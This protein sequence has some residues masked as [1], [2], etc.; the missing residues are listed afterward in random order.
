MKDIFIL[1][2][3]ADYNWCVEN[4]VLNHPRIIGIYTTKLGAEAALK[5]IT[6]TIPHHPDIKY[7]IASYPLDTI[8]WTNTYNV[9]IA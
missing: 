4:D 7:L 5:K 1:Y 6:K 8:D 2:G 9:P 3:E